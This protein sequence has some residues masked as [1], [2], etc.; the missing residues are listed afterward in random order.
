MQNFDCIKISTDSAACFE[1][2]TKEL[3]VQ[4]QRVRRCWYADKMKVVRE[5]KIGFQ[6]GFDVVPGA[7][8]KGGTLGGLCVTFQLL[9]F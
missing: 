1:R 5:Q 9:K 3:S 8:R 7:C 6:L 2:S 4:T